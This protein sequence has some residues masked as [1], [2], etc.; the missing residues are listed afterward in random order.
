MSGRVYDLDER[1]I[2]FAVQI[3]TISD[4]IKPTKA[5]NGTISINEEPTKI[6]SNKAIAVVIPDK[7]P[8]PP[9]LMLI[10]L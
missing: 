4:N 7:R 1:L 3:I 10:M 5:A 6:N 9:D 8:R 2:D